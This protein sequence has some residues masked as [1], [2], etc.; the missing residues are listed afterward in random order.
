MSEGSRAE[1][2]RL[3]EKYRDLIP[4]AIFGILTTVVNIFSYWLCAHQ[5]HLGVMPS[6]IIAW[7]L[8]VLFAYVTNRKWVFNSE[9]RGAQAIFK[10]AAYF[11]GCRL[12]TGFIDWGSMW[13]FAE[14]LGLNDV[15]IKTVANVVVIVINYV[16]S[17]FVIFKHEK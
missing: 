1:I 10:E 2:R 13:L 8:A 11:F 9:A 5:L 12:A 15:V 7:V 16:A 17:K 4:Y 6:T 14:V 3:Y